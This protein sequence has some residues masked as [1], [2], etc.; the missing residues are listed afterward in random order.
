MPGGKVAR[1]VG[2]EGNLAPE[3]GLVVPDVLD[4]PAESLHRRSCQTGMGPHAQRRSQACT[5]IT[6]TPGSHA[7]MNPTPRSDAWIPGSPATQKTWIHECGSAF[8]KS[9][10]LKIQIQQNMQW[11]RWGR[12]STQQHGSHGTY[13]RSLSVPLIHSQI[14]LPR[15]HGSCMRSPSQ[16]QSQI[17]KSTKLVVGPLLTESQ[18]FPMRT[19]VAPTLEDILRS[20]VTVAHHLAPRQNPRESARGKFGELL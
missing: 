20:M 8:G 19:A 11:A 3:S 7:H 17:S 1:G 9:Q 14:R 18:V 2:G 13:T 15:L 4:Y 10:I 6:S 16:P 5:F 12:L